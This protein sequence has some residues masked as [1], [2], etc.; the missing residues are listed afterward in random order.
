ME[1][2]FPLMDIM[3]IVAGHIYYVLYSSKVL[4]CP[5][6]LRNAF[7]KSEFMRRRYAAVA[8]DFALAGN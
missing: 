5:E 7:K 4:P 2:E 3:G 8:D 6:F 1:G